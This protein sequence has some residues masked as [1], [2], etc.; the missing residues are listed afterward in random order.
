VRGVLWYQGESDANSQ[1]VGSYAEKFEAMIA[2]L[3]RD[4]N[5]PEL[6]F[7]LVQL[8]RH[9]NASNANEWNQVQEAQRLLEAKVPQTGVVAAVDTSLDDGIHVSTPD[10]KRLGMRLANLACKDMGVASCQ[11]YRRG[12]RLAS[13]ALE[14]NTLVRVKFNEV[15][16]KLASEGRL[17]GFSLIGPDGAELPVIYKQRV[18]PADS[19]EV[20]LSVQG[21]IPD[22]ATLQYGRGKNPYANLRDGLDMAAPAFGP[23]PLQRVSSSN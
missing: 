17:N 11:S 3:R 12:P 22:G 7:Y 19:S 1:L 5:Q 4:S 15:N 20:L 14:G 2:A 23:V 21:T 9:V 8:G 10:L 18:N 16:G 13:A 6:P